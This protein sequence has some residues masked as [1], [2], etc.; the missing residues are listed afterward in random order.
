MAYPSVI[1][2]IA[3]NLG[4]I[5]VEGQVASANGTMID[6]LDFIHPESAQLKGY[7]MYVYQG[8]GLNQAR[9]ITDYNVGSHQ[10]FNQRAWTTVPSTDAYFLVLRNFK[11]E[12]YDNFVDRSLGIAKLSFLQDM[13]GT[14]NLVATQYE[15]P[16]PSGMAFVTD[17]RLVPSGHS[18]YELDDEVGQIFEFTDHHWQIEQNVG[19]SKVIV[20]DPRYVGM[21]NF[22]NQPIR[23]HGQSRPDFA[24]ATLP[25]KVEEFVIAQ[26]TSMLAARKIKD[27]EEWNSLFAVYRDLADSL[28]P[29]I[30]SRVRGRRV[31]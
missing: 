2:A 29:Y 31:E 25:T 14:L 19:G 6:S 5:I 7:Q 26:A 15:Y 1:E 24:A 9:T 30:M 11:K 16:I 8:G 22:N 20:F 13:V 12:D 17:L 4:D 10:S 27:G 18:D 28:R 23:I 21:D 3:R